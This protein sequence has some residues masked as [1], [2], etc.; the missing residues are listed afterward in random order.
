MH[1]R[2]YPELKE[3][4]LAAMTCRAAVSTGD[5]DIYK[6]KQSDKED[7]VSCYLANMDEDQAS[8]I[9]ITIDVSILKDRSLDIVT[10]LYRLDLVNNLIS[11]IDEYFVEQMQPMLDAHW[12]D[13]RGE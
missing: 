13:Q 7:L 9:E 10:G 12:E 5:F 2:D 11:E 1:I 4:L 8:S 3:E 6:V